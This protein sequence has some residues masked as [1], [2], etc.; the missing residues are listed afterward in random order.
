MAADSIATASDSE[1]IDIANQVLAV[2]SV[3]PLAYGTTALVVTALDSKKD[4]FNTDMTSHVS[5]QAAAKSATELKNAS[6][7]VL[8]EALRSLRNV[9]KA[10]GTSD[11]AMA[12]LGIPTSSGKAPANATV[13]AGSVNTSERLRHTINWTDAATLD[14][15]RKPRGTMGAEIWVK[16]DGPPPVDEKECTFLTLDAFTPYLAEYDGSEAGKM[17]HYMLRWRNRDGSVNAWGETVSA[18]I[19]G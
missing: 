8:E 4:T 3:D 15:K 14:N 5:K 16:L 2:L 17:A 6:R 10:A 1:L 19:T 9:A 11:A 12:A 13:P 18:T 7:D